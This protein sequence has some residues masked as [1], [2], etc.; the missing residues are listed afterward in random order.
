MKGAGCCLWQRVFRPTVTISFLPKNH[1]NCLSERVLNSAG[2]PALQDGCGSYGYAVSPAWGFR[3]TPLH[4]ARFLRAPLHH[5]RLLRADNCCFQMWFRVFSQ[6]NGSTSTTSMFMSRVSCAVP[7]TCVRAA[8]D[9]G[10][11]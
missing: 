10:I 2:R 6:R 4:H 1:P 8:V 9:G 5:A 7:G 11:L 3:S